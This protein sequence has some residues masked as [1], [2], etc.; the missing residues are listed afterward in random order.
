M[1]DAL[2]HHG[3]MIAL[4]GFFAGFLG[5]AIYAYAP[6]NKKKMQQHADIPFKE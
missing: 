3:P 5:I 2:L 1:M 4:I 6:A